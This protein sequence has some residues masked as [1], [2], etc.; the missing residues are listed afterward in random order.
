MEVSGALSAS[1]T[2][3]GGNSDSPKRT[4]ARYRSRSRPFSVSF[5]RL[6]SKD[7]FSPNRTRRRPSSSVGDRGGLPG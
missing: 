2:R 1:P 3:K 5:H 7:V 6:G 4:R